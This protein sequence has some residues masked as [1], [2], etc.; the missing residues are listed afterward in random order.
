MLI[1]LHKNFYVRTMAFMLVDEL[2]AKVAE[3]SRIVLGSKRCSFRTDMLRDLE[4]V[5]SIVSNITTP[6]SDLKEKQESGKAPDLNYG[7]V[8]THCSVCCRLRC[9]TAEPRV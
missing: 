1:K 6:E 8:R 5:D 3:M 2:S 9:D 7:P 4:A